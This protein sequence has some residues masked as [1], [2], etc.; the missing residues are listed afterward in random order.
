MKLLADEYLAEGRTD[1]WMG[2]AAATTEDLGRHNHPTK[3]GNA[4]VFVAHDGA[5]PSSRDM[6]VWPREDESRRTLSLSPSPRSTSS[7][8]KVLKAILLSL[9]QRSTPPFSKQLADRV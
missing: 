2:F 7:C 9:L 1:V 6:V 8:S 5:P 4:A 3:E